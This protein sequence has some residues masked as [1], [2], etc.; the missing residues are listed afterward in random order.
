MSDVFFSA[1]GEL[2]QRIRAYHS[3]FKEFMPI[4]AISIPKE[5]ANKH[6]IE[7]LESKL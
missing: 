6:T 2:F 5:L 7:D 3:N 4:I 1:E